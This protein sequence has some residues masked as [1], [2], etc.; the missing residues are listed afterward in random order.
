MP[1]RLPLT[2]F[3]PS[4]TCPASPMPSP[5]SSR[6]TM[7]FVRSVPNGESIPTNGPPQLSFNW[8][9]NPQLSPFTLVDGAPPQVGEFTMDVD[10]AA[11][12]GFVIG[13]TYQ[14]RHPD[15]RVDLTTVGHVVVRRRQLD[16][17]RS[18]DADEHRPGQRAVRHRRHHQRRRAGR[19]RSERRRR[20]GCGRCSSTDGRG[21]RS[22]TPSRRDHLGIHHARSTSSATSCW[23]SV[24]SQCSC[25]SSSSTTPSRS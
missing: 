23:D 6:P 17:R 13:D 15:G 2:P 14:R 1:R 20:A 3:R 16:A 5:T 12:Y 25:R 10:S 21:R 11:K 24:Q 18:V 8:I 22:R 7:P 9:D 19:R 4:R